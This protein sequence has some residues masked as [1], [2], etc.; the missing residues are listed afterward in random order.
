MVGKH[1]E[2]TK[3]LKVNNMTN[4]YFV[5]WCANKFLASRTKWKRFWQYTLNENKAQNNLGSGTIKT[6]KN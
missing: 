5:I 3:K 4:H 1:Q 6:L 2:E